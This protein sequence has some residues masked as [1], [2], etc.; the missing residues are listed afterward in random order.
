LGADARVLAEKLIRVNREL[1]EANRR[2]KDIQAQLIQT[3][4]MASLGRLVAGIAHEIN[5]PLAFVLNNLFIVENGLDRVIPEAAPHLSE[6][7]LRKLRKVRARLAE[8]GEGLNRVKE[9][10]VNLRSFSRLDEGEFKTI[11]VGASIDSVLRF[12]KHKM[13][14]RIRVEKRYGAA[15][16]LSCYAGRLNQVWMNLLDNAVDAIAG[17]GKIVIRTSQADGLVV[18][19]VRDSGVGIPETIRG[20]I[21]DP[22]FTTKAVGQGTGLGLAI[23]YGIV[24]DHHGSIEVE[25]EI[26]V[27]TEFSVKIPLDLESRKVA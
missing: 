23:S 17:A 25:S 27:G 19:S 16:R 1:E 3:G 12:L 10:I 11:D 26:G 8:M 14:G 2:L 22:F 6:L 7:S 21:F 13:N 15:R 9:P 5:N 18:I 24:Q 20:R 4:K